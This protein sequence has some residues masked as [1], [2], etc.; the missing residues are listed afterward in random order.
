MINQAQRRSFL[1]LLV[2]GLGLLL[3]VTNL[4]TIRGAAARNAGFFWLNQAKAGEGDH[5]DPALVQRSGTF[6]QKATFLNS[7]NASAWRALGYLYLEQGAEDKA[8]TA[9]QHTTFIVDELLAN[10]AQ[11]EADSALEEALAWY[12][13]AVA[14]DPATVNGWIAAGLIYEQIGDTK[15]SETTFSAGLEA[16]PANS[17]L[18]Y[19]LARLYSS[20]S[21]P[22]DWQGILALVDRAIAKDNFLHQ[23]SLFQSHY[24]RGEALHALGRPQEALAEYIIT[25]EGLPDNYWA[26][27]RRAEMTWQ[28]EQNAQAAEFY[29]RKAIAINPDSKWAYRHFARDLATIGRIE[30]ARELYEQVLS[31]DPNDQV[32]ANWLKQHP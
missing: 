14:V 27:L 29:Y 31:L 19:Q 20:T 7:N 24:L 21:E 23:W 15:S 9:W 28:V 30:E 2:V 12:L 6:L 8:L 11:A 25:T 3:F 5:L 10:G 22:V 18:L 32:A 4:T 16:S 1:L 17:D 26:V 13:R